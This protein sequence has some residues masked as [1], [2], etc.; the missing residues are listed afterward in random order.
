MMLATEALVSSDLETSA[1]TSRD[2]RHVRRWR[3]RVRDDKFYG[4]LLTIPQQGSLLFE[5]RFAAVV[6]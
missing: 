5:P 2:L 6:S 1:E 4:G 3:R